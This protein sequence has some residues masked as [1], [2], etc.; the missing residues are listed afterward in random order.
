[1]EQSSVSL[2]GLTQG[3]NYTAEVKSFGTGGSSAYSAPV[4]FTTLSGTP[5]APTFAGFIETT[6]TEEA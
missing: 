4:A 3:T 5:S 6:D 1:V 2:T